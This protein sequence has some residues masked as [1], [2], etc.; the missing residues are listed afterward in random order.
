MNNYHIYE[1]VGR[2]K[3]SVV[4]KGR[5]KKSIEYVAVKSVERGRRKKLMDEVGIFQLIEYDHLGQSAASGGSGSGSTATAGPGASTSSGSS[6]PA[7]WHPNILKFYN[8]YETRNHFWIILEYCSG[9]DLYTLLEQ[10]KKLPE[11]AVKKFAY[12]LLEGLSYLHSQGIIFAD[13]KPSN[14]L[15]NEYCKLKLCDFGLAKKVTELSNIGIK[16]SA[17]ERTQSHS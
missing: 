10:E 2:G 3:Y 4:Y 16:N 8:W 9:G 15:M 5:K 13:L 17:E 14:V 12:E 1:E 6:S 7:N 11:D